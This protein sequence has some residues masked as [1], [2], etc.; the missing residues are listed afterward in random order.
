MTPEKLHD[1]LMTLKNKSAQ[2]P[3]IQEKKREIRAELEGYRTNIPRTNLMLKSK[4]GTPQNIVFYSFME[5]PNKP[6]IGNTNINA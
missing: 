4:N 3:D 1:Y 5:A 2:D 6:K